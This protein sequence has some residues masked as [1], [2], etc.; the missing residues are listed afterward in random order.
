MPK[1]VTIARSN[2]YCQARLMAGQYNE[3]FLTRG[4]TVQ[5]LPG[6]TEE[7]LKK[8]ELDIT[9]PP[10]TVVA[11]MADAYNAPELRAWYCANECPLGSDCREIEEA[12]PERTVIRMQNVQ[13]K[14]AE[15]TQLLAEILDDG[16]IS[17]DEQEQLPGVREELLE[18][19]RRA[20]ET[21]AML[22]RLSKKGQQM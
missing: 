6:V 5:H 1:Q 7:C 11:L 17:E 15:I 18:V 21:L 19:K 14:A 4:T 12:P 16:K 9:R 20:E 2:R 10:N 22:D 8:Y 3:D 13:G